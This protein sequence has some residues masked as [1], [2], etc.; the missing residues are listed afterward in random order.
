MLN[1]AEL[2]VK[3][4]ITGAD[5]AV[6]SLTSV[7]KTLGNLTTSSIAAK[8]GILGVLYE[9][10]QLVSAS[11]LAGMGLQQFASRTG[12][13]VTWLQQLQYQARQAGISSEEMTGSIEGVQKAMASLATGSAPSGMQAFTN[14]VT[15]FDRR[16]SRDIPYVLAKLR[17]YAQKTKATPDITNQILSSFGLS[18][19]VIGAMRTNAFDLKV[20]KSAIYGEKET[21]NLAK[22]SVAWSN[23]GNKIQ[24]AIGHLN[25][26]HGGQFIKDLSKMTDSLLKLVNA[27]ASLSE[28]MKLFDKLSGVMDAGADI[29]GGK[30]AKG[31]NTLDKLIRG[32][33]AAEFTS[34]A[35]QQA[36]KTVN[37]SP[38]VNTVVN[39]QGDGDPDAIA[40]AIGAEVNKAMRQSPQAGQTGGQ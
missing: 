35:R 22:I 20:P 30:F 39:I 9:V 25:S 16:R 27:L 32:N 38:T 37:N 6:E 10:Q 36:S 28:K 2:G 7:Q 1:I 19:N 33:T 5:K 26:A 11:N 34:W 12:L 17:E 8:A 13:S 31:G 24:M 29:A 14:V 40:K 18:G 3:L 4:G 23:L 21:A 15:D